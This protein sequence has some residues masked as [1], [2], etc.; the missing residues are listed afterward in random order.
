MCAKQIGNPF[1]FHDL[2]PQLQIHSSSYT[3]A[4]GQDRFISTDTTYDLLECAIR[5][6]VHMTCTEGQRTCGPSARCKTTQKATH[7]KAILVRAL[8]IGYCQTDK[9]KVGM[10]QIYEPAVYP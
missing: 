3:C 4:R 9:G 6:T 1:P 5:T 7:S 10:S 2:L 8:Q